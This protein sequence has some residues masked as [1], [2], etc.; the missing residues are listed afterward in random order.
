MYRWPDGSLRKE[1]PLAKRNVVMARR[2]WSD[3]VNYC[4]RTGGCPHCTE[5]RCLLH[6][7]NV[8]PR[9]HEEYCKEIGVWNQPLQDALERIYMEE[10]GL[11]KAAAA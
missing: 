11:A 7:F 2:D 6:G 1:K 4:R 3:L 5:G 8:D 10:Q 9:D